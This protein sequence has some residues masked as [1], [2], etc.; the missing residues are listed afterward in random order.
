MKLDQSFNGSFEAQSDT[1]AAADAQLELQKLVHETGQ[2]ARNH[3]SALFEFR[4]SDTVVCSPREVTN[5]L[6][7]INIVLVEIERMLHVKGGHFWRLELRQRRRGKRT[8]PLA[9]TEDI[10]VDYQLMLAGEAGDCQEP[11]SGKAAIGK[12]A[13]L[14]GVSDTAIREIIRRAS[15]KKPKN[16]KVRKQNPGK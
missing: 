2:T 13:Q 1:M 3:L 12:L 16:K 6:S 8:V 11:I 9:V 14:H 10:W 7:N 15:G 5:L 4:N